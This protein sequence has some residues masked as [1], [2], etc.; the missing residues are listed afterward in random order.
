[1]Q[2]LRAHAKQRLAPQ[3][4]KD[5]SRAEKLELYKRFL[6]TEEHRIRLLHRAGGGGRRISHRRSEL[7]D[8][9]LQ[10]LYGDAI[11]GTGKARERPPV[12]LVAVGGYG[13]GYLNPCS[14]VD[15]LFLTKGSTRAL[16]EA[17]SEMIE[18]I[19]YML[20]DCGF[21]VGHAVRGIRETIAECNADNRTK[22]SLIEA[23][24]ICG[25]ED[26]FEQMRRQFQK[27][28]IKGK[29]REYLQMRLK[30]IRTRHAKY[31]G[32]PHLQEPNV[33]E[34]C[35]GLR[36]YQ[37]LL[38]VSYVRKGTRRLKDLAEGKLISQSAF[39]EMHKAHDFLLRVRNELHYEQGRST[40]ILTLRLQGVVATN[41]AYPQR[42]ILRK[43]EAFMLDYYT[44][45]NNLFQ[46]SSELLDVFYLEE[47]E[48]D[49]SGAVVGFLARRKYKEESFGNGF[50]TKNNRIYA[51]NRNVFKKDPGKLIKIF[52]H[53]QVRHLRLSPPLFQ[54]VQR[55]W[56]IINHPF[57]YNTANRDTF[58]AI[59]A[60]KGDVGRA[61]R[62]MHRAGILGR[63]LPEFGA[64]TN[65][66]Q[67]EFFHRYS[68]DE[69][70]L[71]CV[72][73][74][75]G[76]A[77][78]DDP[79]REIYRRLFH[80]LEDPFIL[81]L[82]ILLH[83]SGRA[84][85]TEHHDEAS[86]LLASKVAN[87]L[88]LRSK[89]RQMLLFL[90]DNHLILWRTANTT[91]ID[92]PA[93]ISEFAKIVRDQ[94]RLDNLML[95]TY[96]DSRGTNEEA[97]TE[98]KEAP[99]RVLY[100]EATEYL[101]DATAFTERRRQQ[102]NA[103]LDEVLSQL[104]EEF[105][106]T[107]VAHFQ[108]MPE[109][110]FTKR[111]ATGIAEHIKLLVKFFKN[112]AFAE[113][114]PEPVLHWR[115]I[116]DQGC[117]ELTVVWED[118]HLLLAKIAGALAANRINILS[119]DIFARGDGVVFDIFR[120][121]TTNFEPVESARATKMIEG[122]LRQSLRD[123]PVDFDA[124]ISEADDRVTADWTE[125]APHFPQ[126]VYVHNSENSNRTIVE[127]QALDRIGLL[128]HVFTAIGKLGHDVTNARVTTT[129][130]AAIDTFYVV[131]SNGDKIDDEQQLVALQKGIEHAV[132]VVE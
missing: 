126:R 92:D 102:R 84:A 118:R 98:T 110:Y 27:A 95:L 72:E 122:I 42:D 111:D 4:T 127:I 77:S 55:S 57:R 75:D 1:M 17:A 56:D 16:P 104:S 21:K 30:D 65:L 64:L 73:E 39:R 130:G 96:A 93:T 38:W 52:Q 123:E 29:E 106:S 87:R 108:E 85:N 78:I 69:H 5:L 117:S 132:G 53:A 26:L 46:R 8:V 109:R 50:C 12:T 62:Q 94:E 115:S 14:D 43:I 121:C 70:T 22:S 112:W 89:R 80:E 91:N 100:F 88:C 124:L 79:H 24:L 113:A 18:R 6:K 71:R 114:A 97:W 125:I 90:V 58:E 51:E 32:T 28:C 36:D 54:L 44:H 2:N 59:L 61:L 86:A 20:Y 67:H 37:N 45:T 41:F 15:L 34:G 35:G 66:V 131:D 63:Y 76:I 40:D 7:I 47:R 10:H 9:V 31:R 116:P 129:R 128:H 19:L 120:V 3:R 74:L 107:V 49:K 105:A 119:A 23:R 48:R 60:R 83:D 68:A 101:R 11:E 103:L 33:K 82:A 13:R 25:D 81:Y 99:I